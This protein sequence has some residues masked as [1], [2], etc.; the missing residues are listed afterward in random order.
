MDR[1][2][3]LCPETPGLAGAGD[4]TL[5]ASHSKHFQAQNQTHITPI[6]GVSQS[7]ARTIGVGGGNLSCLVS[8]SPGPAAQ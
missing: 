7:D 2:M 1:E 4:C 5:G 6:P 8:C 3:L